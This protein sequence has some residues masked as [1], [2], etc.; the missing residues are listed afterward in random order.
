MSGRPVESPENGL[1]DCD[2]RPKS[3]FTATA[4]LTWI[5]YLPHI[6]VHNN[7]RKKYFAPNSRPG[8]K[9]KSS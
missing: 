6:F 4:A 8:D 7:C 1:T 5:P 2:C 3:E 9:I